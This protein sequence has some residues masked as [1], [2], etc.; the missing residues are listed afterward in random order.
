MGEKELKGATKCKLI[1][2]FAKNPRKEPV[3]SF[4]PLPLFSS[5]RPVIALCGLGW[6]ICRIMPCATGGTKKKGV[7]VLVTK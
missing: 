5:Y 7:K 3:E 4:H 2:G 1:S 6:F